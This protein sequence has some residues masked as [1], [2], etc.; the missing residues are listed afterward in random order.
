MLKK[1]FPAKNSS[2]NYSENMSLTPDQE[3]LI[4]IQKTW[5]SVFNPSNETEPRLFHILS[6]RDYLEK[7]ILILANFSCETEGL[8]VNFG[9]NELYYLLIEEKVDLVVYKLDYTS[10]TDRA[11]ALQVGQP[12]RLIVDEGEDS[13]V[14]LIQKLDSYVYYKLVQLGQPLDRILELRVVYE[15]KD[16]ERFTSA[17]CRVRIADQV[18]VKV[19][20]EDWKDVS[21]IS[22]SKTGFQPVTLSDYNPQSGKFSLCILV[23]LFRPGPI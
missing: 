9:D 5:T 7:P 6:H 20:L 12:E 1:L 15:H 22:I 11:E 18:Q 19:F 17:T 14:S 2:K 4:R 21:R 16:G 3:P 10:S 13:G 23:T 8:V